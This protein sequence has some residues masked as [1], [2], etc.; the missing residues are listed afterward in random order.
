MRAATG[1]PF[2]GLGLGVIAG[3]VWKGA[4]AVCRWGI[5]FRPA[6]GVVAA[7]RG[8]DDN[9]PAGQLPVSG[10]P[11][12]GGFL[13]QMRS[14]VQLGRT[15]RVAGAGGPACARVRGKP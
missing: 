3:G 1:A 5:G 13:S 14:V 15:G 6:V 12:R 4:P 10:S 8:V 11:V 9:Q 2:A 7:G